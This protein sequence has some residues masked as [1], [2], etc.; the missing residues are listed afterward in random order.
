METNK[1]P[2]LS[3]SSHTIHHFQYT[4]WPDFGVP[5]HTDHFLEFLKHVRSTIQ[6]SIM[7]VKDKTNPPIVCHCSAGIGRTGTF[8]IVDSI[9]C[10]LEEQKI[11]NSIGNS[12]NNSS[13]SENELK[14]TSI[15][16]EDTAKEQLNNVVS[17][18]ANSIEAKEDILENDLSKKITTLD[19]L[20]IFIRKYRM[21]LI[22]TPQQLR[23]C[24][25][26]IVDWINRT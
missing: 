4:T 3:L 7:D 11:K 2:V 26:A 20:V 21:G 18:D 19:E 12:K 17:S 1:Q 15:S 22:Q 14:E 23:F 8:V 16:E 10:M 13:N 5:E 9:L 24:W 25:K 6:N